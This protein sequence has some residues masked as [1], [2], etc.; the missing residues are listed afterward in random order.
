MVELE[1][2]SF[3][4][5]MDR[6]S[7]PAQMQIIHALLLQPALALIQTLLTAA[8]SGLHATQ[9]VKRACPR[10]LSAQLT[11]RNVPRQ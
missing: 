4:F 2:L 11:V 7:P 8:P 6:L 9:E 10:P 1:S 5:R 3:R